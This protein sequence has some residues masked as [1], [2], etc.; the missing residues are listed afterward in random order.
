MTLTQTATSSVRGYQRVEPRRAAILAGTGCAAFALGL[1]LYLTDR[2][3][4][5][6]LL[7]PAIGAL[8]GSNL[9][10]A[11]GQWLPSF[12]HPF[13]F[14]LFT[15]AALA[16]RSVPRYGACV[17]WGAVNVAFEVGQHP[18]VS[19]SLAEVLQGP[20][21]EIPLAQPLARYFIYGTF[22]FG[23]IAAALLGAFVAGAVLHLVHRDQEHNHAP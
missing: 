10:G 21:G 12:V 3:G 11:L 15:A 20:L 16:P 18:L 14:S 23:D 9:F 17:A 1:V 4:S 5:H 22:D 2:V 6:A 7:V 13:S 19:A 8:A